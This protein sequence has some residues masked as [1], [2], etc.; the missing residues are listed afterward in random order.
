MLSYWINITKINER[1]EAKGLD[2]YGMTLESNTGLTMEQRIEH[3]QE[4]LIDGLKYAEHLK[5]ILTEE[6]S[7]ND[8]QRLAQRT[9][10]PELTPMDKVRN[11]CYGLNGEAGECIDL[12]KKYEFQKHDFDNE[13]MIDELGDVMWYCAELASGLGV[14]L[15]D[16]AKHNVEKLRARY[17]EGFDKDRSVHRVI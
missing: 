2:K 17:P 3:L 12:I 9:A 13:K 8:Y 11:G 10:N 16:V 15:E 7:L 6:M 14:T 1:Q 5:A 4:E